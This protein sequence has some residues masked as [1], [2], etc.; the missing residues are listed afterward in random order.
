MRPTPRD[1][2]LIP[3]KTMYS[4]LGIVTGQGEII[5]ALQNRETDEDDQNGPG[6]S[7]STVTSG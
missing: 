4:D 6:P 7:K 3:T 2:S 5:K 1:G